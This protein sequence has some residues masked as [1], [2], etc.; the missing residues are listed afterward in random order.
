MLIGCYNGAELGLLFDD[1]VPDSTGSVCEEL[2]AVTVALRSRSEL[3]DFASQADHKY[4]ITL[5]ARQPTI[6]ARL[7]DLAQQTLLL[8][9]QRHLTITRSSHSV[10]VVAPGVSKL[11]VLHRLQADHPGTSWL[12]IG[13][14]G[15][16]PGN[17]CELL[18]S[19][20]ALSVGELSVD[21][22]TCWYL[23]PRGQRGVEVTL[24]YLRA[25][26]SDGASLRFD[27]SAR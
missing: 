6:E 3:M 26:V 1:S 24:V 25:L 15:R 7:W 13:D 11:N 21:S 14:R 16:W 20:C 17:D 9:G 18:E 8:T 27:L 12:A 2:S 5:E 19:S 10:D 22:E 4:Q 23:A